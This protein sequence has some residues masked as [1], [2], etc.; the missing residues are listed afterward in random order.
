M[1]IRNTRPLNENGTIIASIL[2]ITIFLST[3]VYGLII[4]ANSNLVRARERVL[5]LQAQ[6]AAESGADSAIAHLNAGD[7]A[8]AGSSSEVA[9]SDA[10]TYRATYKVEVNPGADDKE[11]I[12]IATGKVYS[13]KSSNQAYL[14]RKIKVVVKRSTTTTASAILSRNI[15]ELHSGIKNVF[16]REIYLNGYIHMSK[17][18]TN[19]VAEKITVADKNTGAENCSIGGDGNLVKPSSFSDPNQTKTIIMTAYNNCINPPGN[20]SNTDFDVSANITNISKVHSTFIPWSYYMDSTYSNAPGGCNDWSATSPVRIPS[21]GN[22][23][24]THYPNNG[25]NVSASCGSSGNLD[26]GSKQYDIHDHAHI[27]ANFCSEAECNPI[28]NNPT[29]EV[30]Y[31]F[32]EGAVNFASVRTAS[33]SGPVV[34]VSYGTDPASK[35]SVCPLGGA[36]YLGN[37][38]TT[39]APAL[40]MLAN[41]GL[42]LDK[43]KFGAERALG[44]L[45]GK[46]LYIS[47]NPGSPFDLGLDPNFPVSD[48]PIDLAWRA[49]RFQRL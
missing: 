19:I 5:L 4:L 13:P 20:T 46:N 2:V 32:V 36:I 9:F 34:L 33:G 43:T 30:K 14:S 49:V 11:R 15:I 21:T 47:T 45:S 25:N 37:T 18:T 44:G 42:C 40:F 28:F 6:Y 48:V 38:N 12:V 31:L 10:A 3:F 27:R 1:K 39:N 29:S 24:K 35:A 22:T 16:A 8:Y 7:D 17:N 41:N 26:L 23:K